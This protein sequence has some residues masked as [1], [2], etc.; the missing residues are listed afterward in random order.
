VRESRLSQQ[1][2]HG[3]TVS[4]AEGAEMFDYLYEVAARRPVCRIVGEGLF[5][6]DCPVGVDPKPALCLL[7]QIVF[8]QASG[9][10]DQRLELS[11][12]RRIEARG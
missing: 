10:D 11:A 9:S 8:E 5:V 3:A 12:L 1:A 6:L 4:F 2:G 7:A